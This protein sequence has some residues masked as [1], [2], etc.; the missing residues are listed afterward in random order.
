MRRQK[1]N[2]IVMRAVSM[3]VA[4]VVALTGMPI[5]A[6]AAD[7]PV[8]IESV[9]GDENNA[10]T[11]V[12]VAQ[13]AVNGISANELKAEVPVKESEPKG[14]KKEVTVNDI[15]SGLNAAQN[16]L[17]NAEQNLEDAA[18]TAAELSLTKDGK[19]TGLITDATN[20]SKEAAEAVKTM[21]VL[22]VPVTDANGDPIYEQKLDE[23]GNPVLDENNNPVYVQKTKLRT[24]VPELDENG[25]IIYED[26]RDENGNLV[27]DENG[28]PKKVP[29]LKEVVFADTYQNA[30]KAADAAIS[31]ANTA[32]TS[33]SES[34]ASAAEQTAKDELK[35]ANDGLVLAGQIVDEAQKAVDEAVA[36]LKAANEAATAARAKYK[37]LQDELNKAQTNATAANEQLKA[38]EKA[39]D[40]L[41]KEANDAYLNYIGAKDNEELEILFNEISE[42]AK[43]EANTNN[44]TKLSQA[45]V[46]Y[47]LMTGKL[48]VYDD[49]GNP[50]ETK[51]GSEFKVL[52]SF[53][54]TLTNRSVNENDGTVTEVPTTYTLTKN[55]GWDNGNVLELYYYNQNTQSKS[56]Y[57]DGNNFVY[58]GKS[59]S[60]NRFGLSFKDKNGDEHTFYFNYKENID[61]K[62]NKPGTIYVYQKFFTK[63]GETIADGV[64]NETGIEWEN[65]SS[66]YRESQ[67]RALNDG[68]LFTKDNGET[69]SNATEANGYFSYVEA[70]NKKRLSEEFATAKSKVT[71]AS[72]QTQTFSDNVNRLVLDY[73]GQTVTVDDEKRTVEPDNNLYASIIRIENTISSLEKQLES[74]RYALDLARNAKAALKAKIDSISISR[75]VQNS[76]EGDDSSDADDDTS[77]SDEAVYSGPAATVT[78][79]IVGA[80][81]GAVTARTDRAILGARKNTT[82]AANGNGDNV[83]AANSENKSDQINKNSNSKKIT[84]ITN[85]AVPLTG[86]VE[87][88][89]SQFNA[90]WLLAV[91][92]LAAVAFLAK[93]IY[94]DRKVSTK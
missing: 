41:A 36:K 20:A 75:I 60:G 29:K 35:I 77:S 88:E 47:Y 57:I 14:E 67:K 56:A 12:G 76:D 69:Y 63:T 48:T 71:T 81:A 53:K 87:A 39:A 18:K 2:K 16:S 8:T 1:G 74:A 33:T 46:K 49:E 5:T 92:A 70:M 58:A 26:V 43:G 55:N 22:L 28:E 94:D 4:T 83:S 11:A 27:Y 61:K 91:L 6:L 42:M 17:D 34:V 79:S 54:V 15:N 82:P 30:D 93:K 65:D 24:L 25:N 89:N 72:G 62:G 68:Q 51:D 90:L 9:Q 31:A 66:F 45:L 85:Q 59:Y 52:D 23:N 3:A 13:T 32:N 40:A 37:A 7:T 80:G 50:V 73:V 21:Q 86:N 78:E 10:E 19:D 64:V 84:T 38:A 44:L